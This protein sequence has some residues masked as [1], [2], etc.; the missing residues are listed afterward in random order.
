MSIRLY[1]FSHVYLRT[2]MT[3]EEVRDALTALTFL[4][5]EGYKNDPSIKKTFYGSVS[6]D[7]FELKSIDKE[8]KLVPDV[9]GR[10]VGVEREIYVSL[11]LRMIRYRRVYALVTLFWL[12]SFGFA[13][14][15]IASRWL[16]GMPFNLPQW[17]FLGLLMVIAGLLT[18]LANKFEVKRNYSV[19]FFRGL[20]DADE[21]EEKDVPGVFRI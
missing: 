16:S 6:E 2:E 1:P 8:S 18:G 14:W 15:D 19:D 13:V 20:L 10:I 4:S 9:L 21:V 7:E 17:I 3:R 5:D 11:S 12:V